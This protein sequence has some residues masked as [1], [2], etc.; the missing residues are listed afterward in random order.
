MDI[1]KITS[2]KAWCINIKTQS[3]KC[4]GVY[5]LGRPFFPCLLYLRQFLQWRHNKSVNEPLFYSQEKIAQQKG[6]RM[7]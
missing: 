6:R 3:C 7:W 5:L 4:F 1:I 2:D